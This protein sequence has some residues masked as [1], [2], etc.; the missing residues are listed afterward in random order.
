[1][2]DTTRTSDTNT[3]TGTGTGGS[4][5]RGRAATAYETTR[6]RTSEAYAGIRERTAQLSE[7]TGETITANPMVAV[8]GGVAV[9]AVRA[10][11]LPRTQREAELLGPV[12]TRIND[13]AREAARTAADAGREKVEEI[14][15]TAKTKVGEAVIGAVTA[16]TGATSAG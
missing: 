14:A 15:E 3:S 5:S 16:T 8:A 1:M 6:A 4:E 2:T 12:G 11:L 13:A 7:R 9:G 10:A